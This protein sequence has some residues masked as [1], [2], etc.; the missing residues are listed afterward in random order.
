MYKPYK[1]NTGNKAVKKPTA[2][3]IARQQ[4]PEL[5]DYF[6]EE[7][8]EIIDA[9]HQLTAAWP[10]LAKATTSP[11]LKNLLN[12]CIAANRLQLERLQKI[13]TLQGRLETTKICAAVKGIIA[14]INQLPEAEGADDAVIIA[15]QKLLHYLAASYDG[16]TMLAG[17]IQHPASA[18]LLK[19][20]LTELS[21]TNT[22]LSNITVSA[23]TNKLAA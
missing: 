15:M 22:A 21:I 12:G 17:S 23:D 13:S 11:L 20:T 3:K 1:K 16:L 2:K 5:Q 8:A 6:Y 7:L 10:A 19:E 9:A 18:A 4:Q 14:T